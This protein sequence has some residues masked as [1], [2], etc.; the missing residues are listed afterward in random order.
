M[1]LY[2]YPFNERIRTYLRL[3]HLLHRLGDLLV[4]ETVADHHFAL[5]TLFEI[6]EMTGRSDIKTDLLKELENHKAYFAAQRGNPAISQ[7][8]LETFAGYVENA[9]QALKQQRGKPC[10]QLNE[11]DWLMS[12][13]SRIVMPGGTCAFDLPAYHVWQQSPAS[14]RLA[15]LS[16]WTTPLQPL[17][18]ALSLL[19]QMLRSSGIAQKAQAARGQF[20]H[21]LPQGRPVQLMRLQLPGKNAIFP[22]I[23]GNRLRVSVRFMQML[24]ENK[25]APV[26]EDVT[27]ELAFCS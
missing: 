11:D 5:V 23:S 10:S 24:E 15:D 7:D 4:R 8:A 16:R 6:M 2:E 25:T 20:H 3:E 14:V 18:D 22:E 17:A 1:I 26:T 13:R 21:A 27:F 19:L 9:F 12:V